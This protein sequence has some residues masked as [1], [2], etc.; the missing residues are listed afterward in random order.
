MITVGPTNDAMGDAHRGLGLGKNSW[1]FD[2]SERETNR[3]AGM[4]T[5]TQTVKLSDID[6]QSW[7]AGIPHRMAEMPQAPLSDLLL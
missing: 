2:A 5:L 6:R 3:A 1:L 7:L 4:C